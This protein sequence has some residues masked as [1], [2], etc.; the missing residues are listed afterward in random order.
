LV[1]HLGRLTDTLQ[2][3]IEEGSDLMQVCTRTITGA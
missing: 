1:S 3:K 2:L